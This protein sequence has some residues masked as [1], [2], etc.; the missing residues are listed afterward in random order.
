VEQKVWVIG[1]PEEVAEGVDFYRQALSL[2]SLVV[3]PQFP[4]ETYKQADEQ[5]TRFAEEVMPLL[6]LAPAAAS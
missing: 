3:V 6:K 1:S 4:G 2:R 5:M